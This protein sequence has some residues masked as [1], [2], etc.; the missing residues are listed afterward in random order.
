MKSKKSDVLQEATLLLRDSIEI[1]TAIENMDLRY[2]P[3][4]LKKGLERLGSIEEIEIAVGN[5]IDKRRYGEAEQLID[6]YLFLR[7]CER[8]CC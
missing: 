2:R 4:N 6:N 3:N 1:R 5:F 7:G 8:E